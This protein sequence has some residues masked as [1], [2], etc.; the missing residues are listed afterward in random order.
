[1]QVLFASHLHLV[2]W[3]LGCGGLLHVVFQGPWLLSPSDSTILQALE[4]CP[5]SL[6]PQPRVERGH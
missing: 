6:G 4:F 2:G 1:M 3:G 5:G